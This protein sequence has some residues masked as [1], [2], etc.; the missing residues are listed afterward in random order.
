[1]SEADMISAATLIPPPL[2]LASMLAAAPAAAAAVQPA[3]AAEAFQAGRLFTKAQPG[4]WLRL[5][6]SAVLRRVIVDGFS[7]FLR[8]PRGAGGVPRPVP[9]R[10][11]H[12]PSAVQESSFVTAEVAALCA[13]GSV[14]DV[15][16]LRDQHSEVLYV[17]GLLVAERHG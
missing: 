2:T 6:P 17:L 12:A 4:A 11:G 14:S 3:P 13:D 8:F 1:M 15:T 10:S 5:E 7:E 16:H 9:L